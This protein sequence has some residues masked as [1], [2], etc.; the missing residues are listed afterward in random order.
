M[1]DA[2]RAKVD[3]RFG[4]F[5]E[6]VEEQGDAARVR[7]HS[8]REESFYL[9]LVAEG[10]GSTTRELLFSG[11]NDRRWVDITIGYFDPVRAR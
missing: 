9:V 7:F 11:E 3:Y 1:F 2:V 6:A 8:G 4:D 10:V 5:L